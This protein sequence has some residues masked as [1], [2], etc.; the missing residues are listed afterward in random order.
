MAEPN[1]AFTHSAAD[2][3]LLRDLQDGA[4]AAVARLERQY[5]G[6]L[7]LFSQRM[8]GDAAAAEDVVQDVLA[9]CCALSREQAP[10]RSVRGWLYQLARNRCIDLLRKRR[11]RSLPGQKSDGG[12]GLLPIDPC[13][14]PSGK[15]LKRERALRILGCLDELDD[16]L[17]AVIVLRYFQDLSRDQIAEAM[18]LSPRAV[19]SR[20]G[21]AILALRRLLGSLGDS[22][23]Q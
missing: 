23:L 19:K 15:A 10:N 9:R 8:L 7:Q 6:E 12:G 20:I 4:D 11:E 18:D 14:T 13:T 21:K 22:G 17:R 1:Q 5:A 16:E 3:T 2:Q